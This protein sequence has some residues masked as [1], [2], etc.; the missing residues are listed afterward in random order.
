MTM[1]QFQSLWRM[2]ELAYLEQ[3]EGEDGFSPEAIQHASDDQY[4][5][6]ERTSEQNNLINRN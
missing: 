5:S 2:N 4:V 3:M 6:E 1:S